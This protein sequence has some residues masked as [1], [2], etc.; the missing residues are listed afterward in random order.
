M[1][2]ND[3]SLRWM[4]APFLR[5]CRLLLWSGTKTIH[6]LCVSVQRV[7]PHGRQIVGR[8]GFVQDRKR[9][10]CLA[11]RRHGR[12]ESVSVLQCVSSVLHARHQSRLISVH[13]KR[14]RFGRES[15]DASNHHAVEQYLVCGRRRCEAAKVVPKQ[16]LKRRG[17]CLFFCCGR[18]SRF[19]D[20]R[21]G[22]EAIV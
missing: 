19:R 17:G 18:R 1:T 9:F 8:Q 14:S 4:P 12:I 5:S 10:L 6:L 20:A 22:H 15:L 7:R 2:S 11:V 16:V 3:D 13:V 21:I